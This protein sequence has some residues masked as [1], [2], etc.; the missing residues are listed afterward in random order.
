VEPSRRLLTLEPAFGLV[1][2]FQPDGAAA[3]AGATPTTN[4][5]K[6]DTMRNTGPRAHRLSVGFAAIDRARLPAAIRSERMTIQSAWETAG[7]RAAG[8]TDP[9]AE[10]VVPEFMR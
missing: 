1:T 8:I 7:F 6:A 3:W 4:S 5:D 9:G 10:G 2:M